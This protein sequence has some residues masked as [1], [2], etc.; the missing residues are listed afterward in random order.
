MAMIGKVVAMTGV[1][2]LVKANGE[3][4]ELQLGDSIEVGDT[5]KT[6]AGVDVDL[7]LVSGRI[8]HINEIQIVA[9]TEEFSSLYLDRIESAIDTATI[10]TVVKA[11]ESGRDIG[12]VLEDTAAGES[13][14]VNAYGFNFVDLLRINGDLSRSAFN[15]GLQTSNVSENRTDLT[16]RNPDLLNA[17]L[18]DTDAAPVVDS[19]ITIDDISTTADNTPIFAGVSRSLVGNVTLTIGLESI[20]FSPES[21]GS[22]SV[23]WPFPLPDGDYTVTISATDIAGTPVS[24]SDDFIVDALAPTVTIDDITTTADNTPSFSGTSSNTVGDLT[25]TV[26]GIDYAVTP[27]AN[28]DWSF[29]LPALDALADGDYT[30]TIAGDDGQGNSDSASDDFIVDATA[31]VT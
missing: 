19:M 16:N 27:D 24:A 18:L 8:I 22:W 2:T 14:N 29:T 9:F 17:N 31:P 26:N 5:I 13:G 6:P 23:E 21:D 7:E 30:A 15:S 25:L 28:G 11:I 12:E 4:R 3:T 1:A 20:T 10:E